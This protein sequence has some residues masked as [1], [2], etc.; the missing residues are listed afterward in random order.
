[1]GLQKCGLNLN[2][3]KMELL[4]HGTLEFPCVGYAEQYTDQPDGG[5]PWHW[6]EEM[7]ILY[8]REG[9]MRL[10]ILEKTIWLERGACIF[11]NSN[12]FHFGMG[13]PAC[14]LLSI[15]FHP[16][17]IMGNQE[18]VFAQKYILPLISCPVIDGQ[19]LQDTNLCHPAE[20]FLEAFDALEHDTF[21]YEFVVRNKLSNLC[22]H[23]YQSF[24]RDI[25]TNS[26]TNPNQAEL[27][28][29]KMLSYIHHH[30]EENVTLAEIAKAA[31][32][33]PRECLRCFQKSIRISPMQYV[34]EYRIMYGA[35]LL[36]QNLSSSVS[37]I[38]LSCGFSSHSNFSKVFR[39]FY[40]C[41]PREY[42]NQHA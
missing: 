29:Q 34:L 19:Q 18:S 3:A 38:A 32:I 7:E 6:H 1:M 17:L 2:R 33:G 8:V 10:Q 28:M 41:T 26:N 9:R 5:I 12:V 20:E 39:Q 4:P 31:D 13:D 27:R 21:G 11:I 24:V 14:E 22:F 36:L 40:R 15:V 16:L 42:R 35:Q 25:V 37:E 23:L 30:F